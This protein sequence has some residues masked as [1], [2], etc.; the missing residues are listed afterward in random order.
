[1]K[2]KVITAEVVS[3]ALAGNPLGD[4]ATRPILFY[5]PP[6][7][8]DGVERFP[9]VYFL[10]GF[11]GSVDSWTRAGPFA[12]TVPERMDE[13]V[14]TG[15]IPP[16]IGVYVDGWT[17]LGGTQW[18]NSV[19]VG[20]YQDYVAADVVSFVDALLRTVPR[21]EAR[22]VTGKSSG[23]Y[24]ALAMARD[25]A[26]V[27]GHVAAHSADAYFEYCYLSDFPRAASALLDLEPEAWLAEMRKRARERKLAGDD[28]PVLN[29]LAMAASYSPRA[30]RLG[31]ELPFERGS[32]RLRP[33]IWERWLEQDPVRFVPARLGDFRKLQTLF[34]DCGTRD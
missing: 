20:R 21:P 26:S 7:Y 32:G 6:G 13:L 25:R 10:H 3:P 27:F 16:A 22:A 31:F 12:P 2:G 28:H 33:E 23:G 9:V 24:G 11:S 1:M 18:V 30:D 8:D 15:A 19:A 29:V 14:A 34:I 4:P 17:A 5:L